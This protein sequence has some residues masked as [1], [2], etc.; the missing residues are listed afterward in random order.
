MGYG[1]MEFGDIHTAISV[2]VTMSN[3]D[4][5]NFLGLRRAVKDNIMPRI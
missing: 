1:N 4:L 3:F 5:Y 2:I